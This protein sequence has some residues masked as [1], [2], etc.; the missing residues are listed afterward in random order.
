MTPQEWL[1]LDD[2]ETHRT[3]QCPNCQHPLQPVPVDWNMEDHLDAKRLC[4]KCGHRYDFTLYET[5]GEAPHFRIKLADTQREALY[6]WETSAEVGL[7]AR[8]TLLTLEECQAAVDVLFRDY[9]DAKPPTVTDGRG[10]RRASYQRFGH[11]IRL[12]RWARNLRTVV[13][14]VAHAVIARAKVEHTN[15]PGAAHPGSPWQYVAAH[16]PEYAT[17]LLNMYAFYHRQDKR[18][19]RKAGVHQR[20]RRVHFARE[21]Q[22]PQP[23][24]RRHVPSWLLEKG[25][26]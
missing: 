9:V 21:D 23:I 12:P 25:A 5:G 14:E 26:P 11:R 19:M 2:V 17:L 18:P 13:H 15:V 8:P 4:R 6:K 7:A 1:E 16:G 22:A 24:R 3:L 10:S 20:P